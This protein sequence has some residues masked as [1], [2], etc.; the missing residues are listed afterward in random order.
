MCAPAFGCRLSKCFVLRALGCAM[1]LFTDTQCYNALAPFGLLLFHA[2]P[3]VCRVCVFCALAWLRLFHALT[4]PA[5]VFR[6]FRCNHVYGSARCPARAC[7]CSY[8]MV[9][10][11][12]LYSIAPAPAVIGV[13]DKAQG[14]KGCGSGSP[15]SAKYAQIAQALNANDNNHKKA[16]LIVLYAPFNVLCRVAPAEPYIRFIHRLPQCQKKYHKKWRF[17]QV[18]FAMGAGKNPRITPFFSECI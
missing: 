17:F 6:S 12:T 16:V 11:I 7:C 13:I 2:L 14:K 4:Q 9:S 8:S 1:P 15:A 10:I 3:C 18:F 5:R